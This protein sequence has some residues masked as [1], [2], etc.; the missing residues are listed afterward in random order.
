M[1]KTTIS[2]KML[3]TAKCNSNHSGNRSLHGSGRYAECA[4]CGT[5]YSVAQITAALAL[6]TG[7]T[8]AG[9]VCAA[10]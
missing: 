2:K 3:K 5:H 1:N 7:Y 10:R 6:A 9:G 8:G 4:G